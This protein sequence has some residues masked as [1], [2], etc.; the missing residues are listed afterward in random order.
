MVQKMEKL[1]LTALFSPR[2]VAIIGASEKKGKWGNIL[3]Q[4]ITKGVHRRDVHFVNQQGGQILGQTAYRSIHELPAVPELAVVVVPERHF[5]DTLDNALKFGVRAFI[6]ISAGLD[7]EASERVRRKIR[8]ADAV[9]LGP[10]CMG[11]IDNGSELSAAAH[12]TLPSGDIAVL[13]QSGGLGMEMGNRA[14]AL[15]VGFSRFVSLGNQLDLTA[16][17]FIRD[18]AYHKETKVIALYLEH[19][20]DGRA[21]RDACLLARENG[22]RIVLLSPG[23]STATDRA[24]MS[25]TGSLAGDDAAIDAVCR[26]AGIIRVSTPRELMDTAAA[27]RSP[28]MPADK[29]IAIISDGGGAA[30]VAA[31]LAGTAGFTVPEFSPKLVAALA[32]RAHPLATLNNPVD[33][34]ADDPGSI[35]ACVEVVAGSG[36]VDAVIVTGVYGSTAAKEYPPELGDLSDLE[37]AEVEAAAQIGKAAREHVIPVVGSTI[38]Q[39]SPVTDRLA[40]DDVPMYSDIEAA[41]QAVFSLHRFATAKPEALAVLAREI[42]PVTACDYES[43]RLFLQSQGVAFPQARFVSTVD[44]AKAAAV[45]L[46]FPLVMKAVGLLHKSDQGGV[47]LGLT[48]LE[49]LEAAFIDM[50]DRLRAGRYSVEKMVPVSKGTEVI[51]GTRWDDQLGPLVMVGLG[52]TFTEIL[53]DVQTALAPASPGTIEKMLSELQGVEMLR[54]AR[55]RPPADI[56]ALAEL[57]AKVSR[58]AAEH[59]EISEM[60]LNPVL[61]LADKAIALDARIILRKSPDLSLEG[62]AA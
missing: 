54:G 55:G 59:P 40:Q 53:R 10:N 4:T 6:A 61:A 24:A 38:A 26:S 42:S 18:L 13:S 28:R 47:V 12:L 29:R 48:S 7:K 45:E 50:H 11:L 36:E 21:L 14:K 22:K 34:L 19:L 9:M 56:K 27:L 39:S 2:R 41:I 31:D 16:V 44:D 15:G 1:S 57:G 58:I 37:R 35:A 30:V 46:G 23:R 52:G 60:E 49:E 3:A 43:D 33:L 32:A 20:G 51:I 8:A 62:V 25:H 5:E 17:D